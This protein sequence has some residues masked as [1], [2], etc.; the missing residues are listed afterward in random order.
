MDINDLTPARPG[1]PERAPAAPAA[2]AGPV[3][4]F[5]Q[6]RAVHPDEIWSPRGSE[7]APAGRPLGPGPDYSLSV[8]ERPVHGVRMGELPIE[9]SLVS[10][11]RAVRAA[12][13]PG[14]QA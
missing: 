8:S 2:P 3:A 10:A 9:G 12:V 14:S 1:L 11:H 7:I 6:T 13:R 5:T 4:T